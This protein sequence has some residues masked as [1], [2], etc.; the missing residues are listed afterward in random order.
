V[1]NEHQIEELLRR[2]NPE[3]DTDALRLEPHRVQ[4]SSASIVERRGTMSTSLNRLKPLTT[5]PGPVRR[6]RAFSIAAGAAVAVLVL[7]GGVAL[8]TRTGVEEIAPAAPPAGV[9]L[10]EGTWEG[11]V[12][13]SLDPLVHFVALE[14]GATDFGLVAAAMM[15]GVWISEDGTAWHQ[16]LA[17]PYEP[18]ALSPDTTTPSMTI[19]EPAGLVE[20]YVQFVAEYD[21]A[22][23]A[24]GSMATG[25]NTPEIESRVVVWRSED[26]RQWDEITLN[27]ERGGFAGRPYAMLS[28]G[29]ALLVFMDDGS[30]YRSGD[31]ET[32]IRFDNE[33]T[34]ITTALTAVAQF[35]DEY[36]G[37]S[38]AVVG[39]ID[40]SFVATSPDGITWT[41][42]PGSDFP[43]GHHPYAPLVQFEGALYVGGL[44]FLDD[45]AGAVWRSTDGE[46]FTAVDLGVRAPFGSS[47][48]ESVPAMYG[49][50]DLIVTPHGMLVVGH[51]PGSAGNHQDI[52][53]LAT[54]DGM[55]YETV[56]D[57][58]GLFTDAVQTS[59]AL[60]DDRVVM[61][62]HGLYTE[63]SQGL[64]Y[65]WLWTP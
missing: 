6:S 11:T 25:I 31:G 22:L 16:A 65:Q 1:L 10:L 64:P 20:S 40:I 60:F 29:D 4:A 9:T 63:T 48:D 12:I 24:A 54:E 55:M 51:V 45:A 47:G 39:G 56:P 14:M 32:W 21:G 26:G 15:E 41:Q 49:V 34:G 5:P 28:G 58:D 23:Y 35:G 13:E 3:P 36:V 52:V 8:L 62:G 46:T 37:I 27:S 50:E 19:A 7:I 42:V 30:V 57:P 59:G 18:S 2:S 43:V 38:E 53:L 33:E 17:V 44:T 61:V